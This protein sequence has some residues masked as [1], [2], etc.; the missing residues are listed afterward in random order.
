MKCKNLTYDKVDLTKGFWKEKQ[1]LIRNVTVH[2]VYKR[3]S[4]T[5]RFAAMKLN[6]K[7]GE[8][9]C[10]HVFW[11][12]DVAK[13][14]E[15]VAYL[16]KKQRDPVLEAIIDEIADDIER[17]RSK[18]GY[19]NSYYLT[20]EP[21]NR[22]TVRSKHELYCLGHL[23]EGAIAYEQATGKGKLLSLM[24][25]YADLVER[26]FMQERSTAF[27]T[28]GHEEVELALVKLADYTGEERYLRLASFFVD[29]RGTEEGC[30][31]NTLRLRRPHEQDHLPVRQQTEAI[32]HAV[33]AVYLYSAMADLAHR[34]DDDSLKSACDSLWADITQRKMYVT[35]AIGSAR[36]YE[37]RD[38]RSTS[39]AYSKVAECFEEG[40]HLP[41][42]TAYAE[43]CASLGLALFA[44]R[45]A[46][47]NPRAEYADVIE[48]ILYN[49][50]LSTL[51]L[52]GKSFFYSNLQEIDLTERRTTQEFG[53]RIFY[54]DTQ[55][56]EVFDCS[57]CPPNTI[58]F[59]A[60][61]GD[62]LYQYTEDTVYV[63]Q[64]AQSTA[65]I[66]E[67]TITQETDYPFAGTV[68]LSLQ[69]GN[70]IL[71]LRIPSWCKSFTLLH[72]GE[73]IQAP[74]ITNGYAAI[75]ACNGDS[76]VLQMDMELR[77]I[78]TN[79]RVRANR[80]MIA[81]TWGPFVMCMEGVDNGEKLYEV[82]LVGKEA[83]VK[84][85]EALG[86]PVVYHAAVRETVDGLYNDTVTATPFTAKLI[87][88]FAFAN[89]G[90]SDMRI[91]VQND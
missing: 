64:Y 13:W 24:R 2:N 49:G 67:I 21:E 88:Y 55:R 32:G 46:N 31:D 63:N 27:T 60:S 72:N 80:G 45:M 3:F 1:D 74:E 47:M 16:L 43:T 18:D 6:W 15:G 82:K 7:E 77:R 79:P 25:D 65:K 37:I 38:I 85:D 51:S 84:M 42:E 52:D 10:P 17:G 36:H 11:D 62:F 71:K 81:L 59:I 83:L 75:S 20:I 50:F 66:D 91:W 90:E 53:R 68:R 35:G 41:N 40:Y 57:C 4:E 48:R 89:R 73:P 54:P 29:Q 76:I 69:G 8:P 19:F 86:L 78:K 34:L 12:S 5:G 14:V 39:E 22:F 58:R 56:V 30:A 9:N 33:R 44:R 28:P 61:V 23:I 70:R 87:P 26:L